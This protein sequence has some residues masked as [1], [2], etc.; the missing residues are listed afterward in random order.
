M[1]KTKTSTQR[2]IE[3]KMGRPGSLRRFVQQRRNRELSWRRI[4]DEIEQETGVKVTGVSLR[5]W[6]RDIP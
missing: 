2:L 4:A 1:T 6:H 3:L 5:N